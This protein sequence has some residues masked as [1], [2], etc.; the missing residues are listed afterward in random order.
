MHFLVLLKCVKALL[1]DNQKRVWEDSLRE[2]RICMYIL[3]IGFD[4][5][6]SRLC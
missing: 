3:I 6:Y 1:R 5:L 4:I 2:K